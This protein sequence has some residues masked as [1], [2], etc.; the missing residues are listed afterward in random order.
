MCSLPPEGLLD[1]KQNIPPHDIVLLSTTATLVSRSDLHPRLVEYVLKTIRP[2]HQQKGLLEA[3]KEF[4]SPQ[5]V[6]FPLHEAAERYFR[7]GPSFL[8][9]YLPFWVISLMS[10]LKFLIPAFALLL[11]LMKFAPIV[12]RWGIG[13]RIYRW[14]NVLHEVEESVK[15][16]SSAEQLVEG[17][18][19]LK[20]LHDEVAQVSVP[21]SY[22]KDVYDLR[23]HIN[24]VVE[25]LEKRMSK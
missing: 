12:Y 24:L 19:R 18:A 20:G 17:I 23:M 9:R 11:P 14:Y 16:E 7:S 21:S 3:E 8:S 25:E 4:P 6:D 1:F 15:N 5:Y 10:R 13:K 22:R 2:I